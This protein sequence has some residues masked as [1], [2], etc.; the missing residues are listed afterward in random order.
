MKGKSKRMKRY[1]R[2]M[3][4]FT[5]FIVILLHMPLFR[6]INLNKQCRIQW[7]SNQLCITDSLCIKNVIGGLINQCA[8]TRVFT[9]FLRACICTLLFC[10]YNT[11]VFYSGTNVTASELMSVSLTSCH[12]S[13]LVY[14][15]PVYSCS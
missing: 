6:S 9:F 3:R 14:I 8:P 7:H 1:M 15:I 5:I 10:N 11:T 12:D 2:F 4:N 13:V